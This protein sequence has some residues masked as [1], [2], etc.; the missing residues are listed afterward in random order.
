MAQDGDKIPGLIPNWKIIPDGSREAIKRCVRLARRWLA[1]FVGKNSAKDE[2]EAHGEMRIEPTA[3]GLPNRR[4]QCSP[5]ISPHRPSASARSCR[6]RAMG[7]LISQV[8]GLE[9]IYTPRP[10]AMIHPRADLRPGRANISGETGEKWATSSPW[11]GF[12]RKIWGQ[13]GQW[14]GQCSKAKC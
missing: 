11:F 4:L 10:L 5:S 3:V 6:A 12:P 1:P 2:W 9:Y 14:S 13:W 7:N 8:T